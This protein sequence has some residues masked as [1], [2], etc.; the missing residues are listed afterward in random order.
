MGSLLVII[1]ASAFVDITMLWHRANANKAA[2]IKIGI[3]TYMMLLADYAFVTALLI[4]SL[5]LPQKELPTW[6]A[7]IIAYFGNVAIRFI[8]TAINAVFLFRV[9][10]KAEKAAKVAMAEKNKEMVKKNG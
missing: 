7:F 3:S 2:G 6:L 5:F 4:I 10:R 8:N 9:R 1:T